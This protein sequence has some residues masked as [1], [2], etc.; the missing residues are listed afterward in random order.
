[1]NTMRSAIVLAL[2]TIAAPSFAQTSWFQVHG[3]AM[4]RGISVDAQPFE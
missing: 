3:F 1:M 2:I 4:A